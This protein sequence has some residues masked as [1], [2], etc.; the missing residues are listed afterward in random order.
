MTKSV[1]KSAMQNCRQEQVI[2]AVIHPLDDV[3]EAKHDG[4]ELGVMKLNLGAKVSLVALRVYLIA[5]LG[6]TVFRVISLLGLVP[7]G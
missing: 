1:T 3:Q 2:Y 4:H 7:R 6:L 5:V